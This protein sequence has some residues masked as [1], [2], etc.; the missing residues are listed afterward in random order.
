MLIELGQFLLSALRDLATLRRG[1]KLPAFQIDLPSDEASNQE[2]VAI[3]GSGAPVGWKILIVTSLLDTQ[4]WLQPEEAGVDSH[5]DWVHPRCNLHS[6]RERYV[7]AIAVKVDNVVR[8]RKVFAE[9]V[10]TIPEMERSLR[11]SRVKYRLSRRK[12]LLRV[13]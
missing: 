4:C 9:K 7:Y 11:L 6:T 1:T 3:H 8:L 10:T 13:R 2:W 12:R 5:G